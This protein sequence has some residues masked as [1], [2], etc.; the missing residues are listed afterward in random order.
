VPLSRLITPNLPEA[1]ALIDGKIETV[2][3]MLAAGAALG[4]LGAGAVLLKGGHLQGD[5][6]T[7]F[8]FTSDR[9]HRWDDARIDTAHTHGTGCTLA[10]AVATGL[11][12]GLTLPD[13]VA[14]ARAYVRTAIL[15]APG[16]GKGH[17]PLHHGH[18][19]GSF[20]PIA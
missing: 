20:P 1:E 19:V 2:D 13:A 4:A 12:Q 14:R 15:A 16:L 10:S 8:L 3:H 11:A 18:T 7:D 9:V 6:L 17:G 5:T